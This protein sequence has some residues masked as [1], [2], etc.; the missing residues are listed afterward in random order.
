MSK[1]FRMHQ[2][3][4]LPRAVR[5]PFGKLPGTLQRLLKDPDQKLRLSSERLMLQAA[6]FSNPLHFSEI[7]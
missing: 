5:R 3:L 7:H 1:V 6:G 2:R 4:E